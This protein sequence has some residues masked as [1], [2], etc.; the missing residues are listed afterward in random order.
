MVISQEQL[1][2][3]IAEGY[4]APK[5]AGQQLEQNM[6]TKNKVDLTKEKVFFDNG[7]TKWY[8]EHH[9]NQYLQREQSDNLPKL[10]KLYCFIIIDK[11]TQDL[12]LIDDKQNIFAYYDYNLRGYE[13]MEAKINILKIAKHYEDNKL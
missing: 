8:K 4:T 7:T 13:Q 3:V 9:F 11:D 5:K 12:V 1:A 2:M 10:E 6:I